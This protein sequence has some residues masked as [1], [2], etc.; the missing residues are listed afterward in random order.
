MPCAAGTP[1]GS[2]FAGYLRGIYPDI[3]SHGRQ[4]VSIGCSNVRPPLRALISVLLGKW[5]EL[6][7]VKVIPVRDCY[8]A[9]TALK[10]Q[11]VIRLP[12]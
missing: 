3:S 10:G 2:D 7:P 6:M 11:S 5:V 4:R 9:V 1:T 8:I 12:Q